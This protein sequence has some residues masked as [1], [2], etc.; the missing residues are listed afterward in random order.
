M[1]S[2]NNKT[3]KS[4]ID[5]VFVCDIVIPYVTKLLVDEQKIFPLANF[6]SKKKIKY[7]DHN[8][9]LMEMNIKHEHF[10]NPRRLIYNFKS[11]DNMKIYKQKTTKS[12][13]F[14]NI[15]KSNLSFNKQIKSWLQNLN[16]VIGN[17]FQKL[18]IKPQKYTCKK[19]K[20]RKLAIQN[21]DFIMKA[22]AED[23]LSEK[24]VGINLSKLK[25]NLN[26]LGGVTISK[27]K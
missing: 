13:F 4:V 2:V 1:R 20:T 23:E 3:E 11:Q 6:S 27:Q 21:Q 26:Y 5:F 7:S 9:L 12:G 18:R 15:F 8:S 19:F 14:T 10:K 22:I 16:M 24:Q 17:S 25:Y